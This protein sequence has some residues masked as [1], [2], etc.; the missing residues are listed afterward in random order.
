M[1]KSILKYCI[2]YTN[3]LK[4]FKIDFVIFLEKSEGVSILEVHKKI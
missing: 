4:N 1:F 3:Y 2:H